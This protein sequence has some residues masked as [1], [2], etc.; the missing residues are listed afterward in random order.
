MKSPNKIMG[1]IAGAVGQ[2][3]GQQ[4]G[5]MGQQTGTM[6]G[7]LGG[8]T[9][10]E[11]QP[12]LGQMAQ[13]P[14]PNQNALGSAQAAKI[15][16]MFPGSAFNQGQKTYG[17]LSAKTSKEAAASEAKRLAAQEEAKKKRDAKKEKAKKEK[18]AKN[19]VQDPVSGK[20]KKQ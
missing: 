17:I 12:Q 16:G 10:L 1:G 13:N 11:V 18:A 14:Y 3:M 15:P 4:T 19:N 8:T 7:V 2:A 20:T 6:T 9:N 5:A